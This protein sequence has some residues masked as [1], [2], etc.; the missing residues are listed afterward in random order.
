MSTTIITAISSR[1]GTLVIF[2]LYFY[3]FIQKRERYMGI[4]TLAWSL[5]ILKHIIE[6]LIISNINFMLIGIANHV[7][8]ILI[9]LMLLWGTYT[10]IG[11]TMPKGWLYS[12]IATVM[13]VTLG[14]LFDF[15]FFMMLTMT[16]GFFALTHIWNGIL[17]IHFLRIKGI[18]KN[19]TGWS[20]ISLGIVMMVIPFYH[21]GS[22]VPWGYLLVSIVRLILATS[23]LITYFQK[24]NQELHESEQ[25]FRLLAENAQDMIYRYVIKPAQKFQYVSAAATRITGYTPE[26]Y[27]DDPKLPYHIM[28]PEDKRFFKSHFKK[29]ISNKPFHI[30]QIKH[31]D[32]TLRWIEARSRMIKDIESSQVMI[33]GIVRD[34]TEQKKSQAE[35]KYISLHDAL[36]GIYNRAY[37]EK[38]L[39]AL[40]TTKDLPI[41]YIM[42][43]VNGLKFANDVF[44]HER[45]DKLL[46]IIA[47]I[48]Q[49]STREQDVAAR[50]GGDE[51]AM[52]LPQTDQ[53][54]AHDIC[55]Q[56]IEGCQHSKCK[57]LQPSISIGCAT[58]K[59]RTQQVAEVMKLAEDRMYRHKLLVSRSA[60]SGIIV[61]LKETLFMKS[62]ETEEHTQRMV[63]M[64]KTIRHKL[65]LVSSEFDMLCLLATLHDIGKIA[66]PDQILSKPGKLSPEEWHEMK[67]HPEVGYRIACSTPELSHI[68]EYILSHHERWNGMGY[69]QGLKETEIPYL[70][71]IISIID[72]YDVMT[73]ARPYKEAISHEEALEE[74][75]RCAGIQFDPQIVENFIEILEK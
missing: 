22:F 8:Y 68:A 34:V 37:F 25:Y 19:M 35:L 50:W 28:Y 9:G 44:G 47:R 63:E 40:D 60:R 67:K 51:F 38:A 6:I 15:P 66:I 49:A 42:I 4:W 32:G 27:Y 18:N 69:P 72:A 10:F 30:F 5:L 55:M 29:L 26:E 3:L 70:S 43:D 54:K 64:V 52:I 36:T 75:K 39:Q 61:S 31:K 12:C 41:S 71:R 62:C 45:G 14:Q 1:L 33:E 17:F 53:N 56:I 11:I 46:Q 73:H 7:V 48:L 21:I 65:D 23:N 24:K 13:A 59:N 58:M 57:V 20:Y 2:F 74:I 16:C